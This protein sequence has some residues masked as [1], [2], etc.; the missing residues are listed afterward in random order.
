MSDHPVPVDSKL[1]VEELWAMFPDEDGLRHELID[2][3]HFVTSS[4]ATRH[5]QLVGRLHFEIELCLRAHPRAGQVFVAPLDVILSP[6]DLVV[7]DLLLIADDQKDILTA[8]NVQGAPALVIEILSPSTRKRDLGIKRQLFRRAGVREYWIVDGELNRVE[9]H[10]RSADGAL[11]VAARLE[12]KAGDV[13]TSPLFPA[14][15]LRLDQ[16]FR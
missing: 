14:L 4:P 7:P 9:I 8:K 12:A 15:S 11:A 13:L 5:Q 6:H 16:L 10:R 1:T 2:G 3:E